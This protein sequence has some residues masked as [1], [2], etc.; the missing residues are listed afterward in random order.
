M[1]TSHVARGFA[2]AATLAMVLAGPAVLAHEAVGQGDLELV[3][4]F[5]T[6][7]AYAGLPNS[8]QVTVTHGGR[9][10]KPS[11]L[12]LEVQIAFGNETTTM[13]LKP[14]SVEPGDYRAWFVPSQPGDYT[15]T[16]TG[17]VEG[18]KVD[19]SVTSGPD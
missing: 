19:E 11:E 1:P 12:S 2:A 10:V 9:P 5:G 16:V 15:F 17:E 7:P 4:G 13:P 6:E 14:A 8:V 18:E 3:I